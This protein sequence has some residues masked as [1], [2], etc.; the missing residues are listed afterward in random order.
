MSVQ[1]EEVDADAN[2][3]WVSSLNIYSCTALVVSSL[4]AEGTS[5]QCASVFVFAH[6]RWCVHDRNLSWLCGRDEELLGQGLE[7]ND[8]LQ[9]VLAKHDAI[10]SGRPQPIQVAKIGPKPTEG[11]SSN[12]KQTEVEQTEVKDSGSSPSNNTT[13]TGTTTTRSHLD[14]EDEEEDDFA[15]LARRYHQSSSYMFFKLTIM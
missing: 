3:Y 5:Y 13:V 9:I 7:L 15:Q 11:S 4:L 10:A 8:S 6:I 14:E 2:Y 1:P 12:I